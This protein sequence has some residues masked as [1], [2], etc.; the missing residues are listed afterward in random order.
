MEYFWWLVIV[1]TYL[2]VLLTYVIVTHIITKDDTDRLTSID[3]VFFGITSVITISLM[4][5]LK[6]S[7]DRPTSSGKI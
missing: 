7:M 5:I 2:L 6:Y 4:P 1:F 3:T